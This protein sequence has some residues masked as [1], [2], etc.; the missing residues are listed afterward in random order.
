MSSLA[1]VAAGGFA[2][3]DTSGEAD[4]I[5][6]FSIVTSKKVRPDLA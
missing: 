3:R 1:S 5:Q 6:T 4:P 2:S